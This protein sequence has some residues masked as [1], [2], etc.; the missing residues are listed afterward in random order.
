[1]AGIMGVDI[2]LDMPTIDITG[3]LSSTWI[4]VAIVAFLGVIIIGVV[5]FLLYFKTFNKKIVFFDNIS[6][7]GWQP[8]MKKRARSLRI[9]N[10]GEELLALMGGDT[11]T[12]YGRKMGHNTYWFA[13]SQDGYWINFLLGDLDAKLA[14]L[15]I[16]PVSTDVRM[17]HVAKDRMNKENYLKRSFLEKYGV[18]IVMVVFLIIFLIGMWMI[19]GKINEGLTANSAAMKAAEE[20]IK[21]TQQILSANENII[22]GGK[23][24]GI[25]PVI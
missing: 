15:D 1:M 17:F 9:S 12:A 20:V 18:T 2:G 5:A 16:E 8:V 4:Y 10:T 7:L 22:N 14:T 13:K 19:V 25:I 3:W 24:S 21:S 6:G 23:A 11:I